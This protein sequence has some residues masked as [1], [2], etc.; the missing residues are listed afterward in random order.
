MEKQIIVNYATRTT[1]KPIK[2]F[3]R[4]EYEVVEG[5]TSEGIEYITL[6]DRKIISSGE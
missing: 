5:K 1:E 6:R 3:I 2:D 4:P